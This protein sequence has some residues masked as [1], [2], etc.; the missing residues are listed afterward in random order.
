MWFNNL[1]VYQLQA[2]FAITHETMHH[3]LEEFHLKPCPAH[4]RQ[5]QGFINPFYD[6]DEKLYSICNC[7]IIVAANEV[8]LLPASVINTIL[9]EKLEE[10]ELNQQRRM[11]RAEQLQLK[12]ELEFE[13]LPKAFIVQKKEWLYIDT[14]K[15]WV[16]IN[17]S[18]P[19]K[20][21]DLMGLLIKALGPLSAEPLVVDISLS[22]LFKNWL[23]EP[24]SLPDALSLGRRCMLIKSQD[25]KSQY[26][27]KDIEQNGNEID[28]LLAEGYCSFLR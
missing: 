16:V 27:C 12:E 5:S 20:A 22:L 4:A 13:L 2:P 15:Q 19:N 3:A 18:N 6:R 7:H 10:F 24:Q 26:I 17:S 21:A 9:N 8:R 25:D 1:V 11:R 14:F 23:S 28:T